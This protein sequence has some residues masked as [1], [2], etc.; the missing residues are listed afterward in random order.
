MIF[1]K[2]PELTCLLAVINRIHVFIEDFIDFFGTR[3][4]GTYLVGKLLHHVSIMKPNY[5]IASSITHQPLTARDPYLRPTII[6]HHSFFTYKSDFNFF[7]KIFLLKLMNNI[8][9]VDLLIFTSLDFF[10]KFRMKCCYS[11]KIEFIL[12]ISKTF[13]TDVLIKCFR[14]DSWKQINLRD[15]IAMLN[16]TD[17]SIKHFIF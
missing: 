8:H 1:S 14:S 12:I 2:T 11:S 4:V 16:H 15:I 9:L 3:V 10:G 13:R 5:F 6:F 7:L 17:N